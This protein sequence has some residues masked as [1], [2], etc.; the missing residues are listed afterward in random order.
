MARG[1]FESERLDEFGL[2]SLGEL[3]E[4]V[5]SLVQTGRGGTPKTLDRKATEAF[6]AFALTDARRATLRPART[7]VETIASAIERSGAGPDTRIPGARSTVAAYLRAA[8]RD[9]KPIWPSLAERLSRT[10]DAL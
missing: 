10:R 1:S 6:L 9:V 8:I 5:P 3:G 4:L 7:Q 2:A